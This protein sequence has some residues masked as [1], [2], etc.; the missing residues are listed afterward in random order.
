MSAKKYKRPA[1]RVPMVRGVSL[2]P[3]KLPPLAEEVRA[4]VREEVERCFKLHPASS[5]WR[6]ISDAPR[7]KWL[8]VSGGPA[9]NPGAFAWQIATVTDESIGNSPPY[10]TAWGG[11]YY[12]G[13]KWYMELPEP[14]GD[15]MDANWQPIR[16][17]QRA[18]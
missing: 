5:A 10:A 6:P 1:R 9:R 18:A 7:N 17:E 3:M 14:P 4:I 12:M 15:G 11:G 8:L 16:Q 2:Q 13:V